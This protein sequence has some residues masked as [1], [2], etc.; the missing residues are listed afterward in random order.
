MRPRAVVAGG[1]GFVGY[2]FVKLLLRNDFDVV[3]VDNLATG[4]HRNAEAN[5]LPDRCEFIQHDVCEPFHVAGPVDY[6]ANLA[7]PASPV[8]FS[9]IPVDI[10]RVCSEGTGNLLELALHKGAEFL[11]ASTSEIYGD[12]EV[13]PQREEY[14]GNVNI[15]GPRAVY[16]EGKRYAEALCF[17][18]HRKYRV[19]IHV[20]RIF[21][22]YG[23]RMRSDDGR[24]VSN[25]CMQALTGEP[26]TIYG[27]GAQT[28]SFCYCEDEVEGLYRLMRS[29]ETGPM[30]IGN[31]AE[32]S[33]REFAELVLELTGSKSELRDVPLLHE[34]DPKRRRPDI[35]RVREKL[36]WEPTTDLR[37]GLARTVEWF[38][39]VVRTNGE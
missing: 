14:T 22:T 36:G 23:P 39:E 13:H 12:P 9:R 33:I 30:N 38:A 17:A 15:T 3:I 16:D 7:C 19:P 26:L 1:A 37:T 20:A 32:T 34:D 10:M 11:Q 6:V 29:G 5:L 8:D 2:H 25:F 18:Y 28:R 4:T 21:N 31:P 24:V 35:T 27:G